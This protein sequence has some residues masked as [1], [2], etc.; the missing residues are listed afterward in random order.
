MAPLLMAIALILFSGL[1]LRPP[2]RTASVAPVGS[3]ADRAQADVPPNAPFDAMLDRY[4]RD[5]FVYYRALQLERARFDRYVAT[6]ALPSAV[7]DQSSRAQQMAFWLNAYN[8]LVLKTVIDHYPIRGQ[9]GNYPANSIRQIPGAF[10][11]AQHRAAGRLVTLDEIEQTI[12]SEFS[13]PRVQLALGRGAIGSGR[14]L[15]EAFHADRLEAQLAKVVEEFVA[16]PRHLLVDRLAKRVRV[17]PIFGWHEAAFAAS[18]ADRSG[19]FARRSP[20]ER[21][22]LTLIEPFLLPLEHAFLQTD[23]FNVEYQEFDWRLN[24]LTGR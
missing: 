16:T 19:A 2:V 12:L 1:P 8:V 21:A 23:D 22:I 14:L 17:S 15:S 13:D 6:L 9:S 11:R 10:A 7:Y 18:Y 3:T 4:V 20:I 5:G 24:D